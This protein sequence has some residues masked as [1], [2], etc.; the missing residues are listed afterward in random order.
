MSFLP[1]HRRSGTFSKHEILLQ[2]GLNARV[3][4]TG[5]IAI[6]YQSLETGVGVVLSTGV[7]ILCLRG[8]VLVHEN[9]IVQF[10]D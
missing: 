2:T 10:D 3:P 6:S 9:R 5:R 8:M 4:V 1:F 7:S